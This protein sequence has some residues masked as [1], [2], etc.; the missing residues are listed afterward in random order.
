MS[1]GG[2]HPAAI[3]RKLNGRPREWL[4][5]QERKESAESAA[6]IAMEERVAWAHHCLQ[7]MTTF[8]ASFRALCAAL[9]AVFPLPDAA[10]ACSSAF[11]GADADGEGSVGGA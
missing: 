11:T 10:G 7:A 8:E 2:H 4:S 5:H 3:R 9:V 1:V 6:A